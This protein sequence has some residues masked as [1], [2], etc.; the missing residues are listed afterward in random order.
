MGKEEYRTHINKLIGIDIDN[1][2]SF[3]IL[4]PLKRKDFIYE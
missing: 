1:N 2:Y 4:F 3:I